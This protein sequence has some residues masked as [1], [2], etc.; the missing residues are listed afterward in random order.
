MTLVH[1]TQNSSVHQLD[2][3][4]CLLIS[5][6]GTEY[7]LKMCAFIALK[8]KVDRI[9]IVSMLMSSER[10]DSLEIISM[11]HA[12]ELMVLTLDEILELKDLLVGTLVLM[13]LN[14][15]LC[16]RIHRALI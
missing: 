11:C 4:N 1:A 5:F 13:E 15:I 7:K 10:Y 14:S 6:K 9:D 12:D 8:A 16:Q 3:E 2:E